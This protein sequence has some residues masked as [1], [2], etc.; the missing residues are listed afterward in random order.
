MFWYKLKTKVCV[1]IKIQTG[2]NS[3][4]QTWQLT[5][6]Y[7]QWSKP[8]KAQLLSCHDVREA[9]H[10]IV[11]FNHM[12]TFGLSAVTLRFIAAGKHATFTYS[13]ILCISKVKLN[14]STCI[15]ALFLLGADDLFWFKSIWKCEHTDN[16]IDFVTYVHVYKMNVIFLWCR[17]SA[18]SILSVLI[19]IRL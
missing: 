17:T 16:L 4:V 3:D 11:K 5:L 15:V 19:E 9:E 13:W 12:I 14:C 1:P 18:K 6:K 10:L 8:V 7:N 2:F